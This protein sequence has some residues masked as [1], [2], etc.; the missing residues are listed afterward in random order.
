MESLAAPGENGRRAE[1]LGVKRQRR[2]GAPGVALKM[3]AARR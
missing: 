1:E 3:L 2:G